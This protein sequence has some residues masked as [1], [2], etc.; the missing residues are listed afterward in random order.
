[1]T[2]APRPLSLHNRV[3]KQTYTHEHIAY[4]KYIYIMYFMEEITT[5]LVDG[6]K[7]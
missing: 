4:N 2:L 6:D 1:V 3:Q 7:S 5:P